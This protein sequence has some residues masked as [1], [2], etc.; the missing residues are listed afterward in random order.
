HAY[1][2]L[3]LRF[4]NHRLPL[5]SRSYRDRQSDYYPHHDALQIP[6]NVEI[7]HHDGQAVVHAQRYRSRIHHRQATG[8]DIVV[9]DAFQHLRRGVYVRVGFVD[10]GHFGR[11]EDDFRPDLHGAQRG[12]GIRRKVRIP[13]APGEDDDAAFLEVADGTPPDEGFGDFPD[14]DG[15]HH[16]RLG[17]ALFERVLQRHGIDDG[18]EH[19]HMVADHAV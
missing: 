11:L 10:A 14:L 2:P 3:R 13:G 6:E 16:A 15:R 4:L 8:Q 9:A 5:P 12:G 19:P 1:P 18:R 17:P 7:E